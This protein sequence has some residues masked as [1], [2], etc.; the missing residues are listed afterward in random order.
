ML[1]NAATENKS[2]TTL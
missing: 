1:K 2:F